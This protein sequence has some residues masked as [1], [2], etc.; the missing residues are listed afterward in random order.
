MTVIVADQ[1]I[2]PVDWRKDFYPERDGVEEAISEITEDWIELWSKDAEI[3]RTVAKLMPNPAQ[4]FDRN[5]I[6]PE[7]PV[8]TIKEIESELADRDVDRSEETECCGVIAKFGW[9]YCPV[10][11]DQYDESELSAGKLFR[12]AV[13]TMKELKQQYIDRI[14][15]SQTEIKK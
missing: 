12:E 2:F 3:A 6:I 13:E 1:Y 4:W 10:C 14:A 15:K 11:G 8:T 9:Q 5:M 7:L